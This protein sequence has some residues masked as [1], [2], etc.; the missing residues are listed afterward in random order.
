MFD[1]SFAELA[2]IAVVAVVFIG[3]KELPVVVKAVAKAMRSVRSFTAE[4]RKAFDGLAHES[5][6][7]DIEK[8]IRMIEGDDG[9]LHEAYD[10]K[11]IDDSI[12][13]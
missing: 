12:T 3:P 1:F 13:G 11:K 5:G 6:L 4:F 7:K 9:K 2:L 8:D 10:I